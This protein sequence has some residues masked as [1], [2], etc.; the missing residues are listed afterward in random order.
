QPKTLK[1]YACSAIGRD[2]LTSEKRLSDM[3]EILAHGLL[4]LDVLRT[5]MAPFDILPPWGWRVEV[6]VGRYFDFVPCLDSAF[7]SAVS[8][9]NRSSFSRAVFARTAWPAALYS[10]MAFAASVAR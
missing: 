2:R 6:Q 3:V 10:D 9:A 4:W 1:T 8:L 5:I 7:L